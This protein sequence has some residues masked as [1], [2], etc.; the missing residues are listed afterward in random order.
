MKEGGEV[1]KKAL[2]LLGSYTKSLRHSEGEARKNTP[3]EILAWY[4]MR[5]E[6]LLLLNLSPFTFKKKGWIA[7]RALAMTYPPEEKAKSFTKRHITLSRIFVSAIF[8]C[9]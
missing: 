4:V 8:T 2:R 3:F 7:S 9:A 1:K 5:L 6:T